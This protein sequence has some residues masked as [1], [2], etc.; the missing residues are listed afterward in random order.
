MNIN[1]IFKKLNE[2]DINKDFFNSKNVNKVNNKKNI[3]EMVEKFKKDEIKYLKTLNMEDCH[4]M[5][6]FANKGYEKFEPIMNNVLYDILKNYIIENDDNYH[7]SIK[8]GIN[9]IFFN[10]KYKKK[11]KN[12]QK[13]NINKMVEKFKNNDIKYLKTL[14]LEECKE[15]L[16]FANK[17]Y[18]NY[19]PV[20]NNILYDILKQY[21]LNNTNNYDSQLSVNFLKKYSMK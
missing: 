10:P 9:K 18:T 8:S 5:L 15:I 13:N 19:E 17:H 4:Y 21:I 3:E 11:T 1:K 7:K 16:I 6:N 20:M 2:P 12:I 14:N